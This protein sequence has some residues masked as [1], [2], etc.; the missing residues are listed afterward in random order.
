LP[1]GFVGRGWVKFI[2]TLDSSN[3]QLVYWVKFSLR[4]IFEDCDYVEAI[5][6]IEEWF[7][8]KDSPN[9]TGPPQKIGG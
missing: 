3:P 7:E 4:V 2:R 9:R 8:I 6:K 5:S 1:V